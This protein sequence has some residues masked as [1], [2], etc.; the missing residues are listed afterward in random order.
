MPIKI[1]I[2]QEVEHGFD[3]PSMTH[4]SVKHGWTQVKR[5]HTLVTTAESI[6]AVY[7]WHWRIDIINHCEDMGACPRTLAA[8]E[9]PIFDRI[10]SWSCAWFRTQD[11]IISETTFATLS[12]AI[13][14]WR[15]RQTGLT[16]AEYT[17]ILYIWKNAVQLRISTMHGSRWRNSEFR[18]P[19]SASKYVINPCHDRIWACYR[20][21][22]IRGTQRSLAPRAL[23]GPRS[24]P[25]PL[26]IHGNIRLKYLSNRACHP[27][28]HCWD[29]Y[30]HNHGVVFWTHVKWITKAHRF[31]HRFP[32]F[33]LLTE[34]W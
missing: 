3:T 1:E 26:T 31:N 18:M 28:S 6:R 15:I 34:A 32:I 2:L 12:G 21:L 8:G 30:L 7:Y 14:P 25:V 23:T 19:H 29:D 9:M 33:T 10:A 17:H 13:R 5:Y 16:T 20:A 11:H 4:P 27:S 22:Y 24:P